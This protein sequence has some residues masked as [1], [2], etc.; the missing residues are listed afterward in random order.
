MRSPQL[1]I[2]GV[3]R[4]E[5]M[6]LDF[7]IDAP[8]QKTNMVDVIG[9]NGSVDLST[10]LTDGN[11]VYNNRKATFSLGVRSGAVT[12]RTLSAELH[13]R[14]VGVSKTD[15]ADGYLEGRVALSDFKPYP[16]GDFTFKLTID[17]QPF[18][19][20]NA[21][22]SLS[23]NPATGNG[24]NIMIT[25]ANQK[26]AAPVVSVSGGVVDIVSAGTHFQI[27][28]GAQKVI[29]GIILKSGDNAFTLIGAA[30]ALVTFK[31]REGWL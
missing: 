17:A 30:A 31:W 18:W 22:K 2:G 29:P 25:N 19:T 13:G 16:S 21:E 20:A 27:V 15:E 11:P 24:K 12:Q 8:E 9:A 5:L 10:V 1:I 14:I 4:P 3:A 28:D 23:F 7:D 26:W 6:V